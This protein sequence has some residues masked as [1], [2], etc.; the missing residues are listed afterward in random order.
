MAD[1]VT[2][3]ANVSTH[4]NPINLR[5]SLTGTSLLL[6]TMNACRDHSKK[7]RSAKPQSGAE[8]SRGQSCSSKAFDGTCR[9]IRVALGD[10]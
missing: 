6:Q 1:A 4:A 10:S 7:D 3:A 8:L 2:G 9:K 5:I